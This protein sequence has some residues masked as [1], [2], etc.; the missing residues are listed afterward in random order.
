VASRAAPLQIYNKNTT[1]AQVFLLVP[2][3]G[4][5]AGYYMI[6]SACAGYAISGASQQVMQE[7]WNSSDAQK[8]MLVPDPLNGAM[9]MLQN[10]ASQEFVFAAT[11]GS[12]QYQSGTA[13]TT[14]T[15]GTGFYITPVTSDTAV[16][17]TAATASVKAAS[18]AG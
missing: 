1:N 15:T 5:D 4:D 18:A 9:V 13:L 12:G 10:K 3:G 14:S 16:E 6:L 7:Q 8:W 17:T 11:D 2:L